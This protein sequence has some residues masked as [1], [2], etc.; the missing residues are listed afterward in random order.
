[1]TNLVISYINVNSFNVS[2]IGAGSLKIL[3][4]V[5]GVTGGGADVI[6][7]SDIR[8]GK[9]ASH[10][11]R[12]FRLSQNGQY[13]LVFNST[14]DSRGVGIAIREGRGIEI[15]NEWR[16]E[17]EENWLTLEV[18]I[19]RKKMLIGVIYGPNSNNI[20]FYRDFFNWISS[21]NKEFIIGGDFNTILDRRNNQFNLDREGEG[22]IPNAANSEEINRWIENGLCLDPYRL[23]YPEERESSYIPFRED[24][25]VVRN[26]LD[27]C[28]TTP[29]IAAEISDVKYEDRLSTD[30][31]HKEVKVTVGKKKSTVRSERIFKTNTP[32]PQFTNFFV[33]L[34]L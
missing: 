21:L 3:V 1:M 16:D 28:L 31:D 9:R 8:L 11:E 15:I 27:F 12:L 7:M 18:K 14:R 2:G 20:R 26:R 32:Y 4:K 34:S 29:D 17:D 5:E 10:V 19:G 13:K 25:E 23:L 22:N 33:R 6:C 24:R 30:F